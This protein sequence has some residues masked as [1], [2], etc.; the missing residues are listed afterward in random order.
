MALSKKQQ[1]AAAFRAKHKAKVDAIPDVPEADVDLAAEEEAVAPEPEGKRKRKREGD[2][3]VEGEV[4]AKEEAKGKGKAKGKKGEGN[5]KKDGD[6]DEEDGVEEGDDEKP[7]KS[8]DTKQRF[9]L[10]IGESSSDGKKG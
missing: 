8:K 5:K 7:K 3:D 9:I 1:K 6:A 10:F 4:K 2:E